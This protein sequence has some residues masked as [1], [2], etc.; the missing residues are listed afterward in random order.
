MTIEPVKSVSVLGAGV[1]GQGIAQ[2]FAMGGFP[3]YLYD[4]AQDILVVIMAPM[5]LASSPQTVASLRLGSL[6]RRTLSPSRR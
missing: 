1:M 4:I 5:S 3:V 2:S 6:P